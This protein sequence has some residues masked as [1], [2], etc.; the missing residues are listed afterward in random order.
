[1]DKD[2]AEGTRIFQTDNLYKLIRECYNESNKEYL[3]K[4]FEIAK[5]YMTEEQKKEVGELFNE[6]PE[7][8]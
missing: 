8:R 7:K 6:V 4:Q 3:Q 5:S 2:L 1:M